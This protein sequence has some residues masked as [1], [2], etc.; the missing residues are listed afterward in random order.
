MQVIL[1][2]TGIEKL[3]TKEVEKLLLWDLVDLKVML[4]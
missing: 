2:N 3:P 1:L 4:M